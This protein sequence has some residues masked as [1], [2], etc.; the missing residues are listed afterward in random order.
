[1]TKKN[2]EEEIIKKPNAFERLNKN[3][4]CEERARKLHKNKYTVVYTNTEIFKELGYTNVTEE[5]IG[6]AFAYV[7]DKTGKDSIYSDRQSDQ[8]DIALSGNLGSGRAG[9]KGSEFN[10]K[11]INRTSLAT[12]PPNSLHGTGTLDLVTA[13]REAI[14]SNYIYKNTKTKT[15]PVVAVIAR[16][17]MTTYCWNETPLRN[18]L[19]VRVDDGYLDRVSHLAHSSL[20]RKIN[21]EKILKT[22]AQFDAELF[23]HR[24]LHGAWSIGNASLDG[25]WLDMESVSFTK[26]RGAQCNITKKF[27]S[28]YFGYEQFGAVQILMQLANLLEK[29]EKEQCGQKKITQEKLMQRFTFQRNKIMQRELARLLGLQNKQF[30][31]EHL[32]SEELTVE[33]ESLAKKM[34]CQSADLNVFSS[35]NSETH[36]LDFSKLFRI[37]PELYKNK[38]SI[39]EMY[40]QFIREE[41]LAHCNE[42]YNPTNKAEEYLYKN[43][44]VENKKNFTMQTKQFLHILQKYLAYLTAEKILPKKEEWEENCITANKELPSFLELTKKIQIKVTDFE[45]NQLSN[46]RLNEWMHTL[47]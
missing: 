25:N 39:E 26:G 46:E 13:L 38:I 21:F 9:Y 5:K 2:L 15:S 22:Y 31:K 30:L 1:M 44:M 8:T 29:N 34:S 6:E 42:L 24:I 14:L 4:F 40:K 11:G 19:L 28:N 23:S 20:E 37:L 18:A 17:D 3:I 33:W 10:I 36:L 32:P 45:N 12:N 16:N 7:L 47:L 43:A 27:I 41:E 35:N